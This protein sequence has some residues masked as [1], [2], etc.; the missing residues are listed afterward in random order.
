MQTWRAILGVG[1]LSASGM[2]WGANTEEAAADSTSQAE[3]PP[4]AQLAMAEGVEATLFASGSQLFNP[5]SIDVDHRG[6][7]WVCE[8]VNYRKK[9]NPDGD[10]IKILEDTDGD[11]RADSEKTFYQGADIDGGH[12]VCV[13]GNQVIV[14]VSDRI[15][16]LTDSDGDDVADSKKLLFKGKVLNPVHGQHD[17]AIHSVMFGPDGRLYFNFGNFNS[18]LR[19]ENGTVVTDRFGQPVDGSRKPYMDGMVIRCELDGSEV[20]VLGY[21]FR[22]NWEVTV[23]SFGSMWQSDND[24]G[25]SSCRVNFVMEYGNYGY[26]D[27]VTGLG[28]QSPRT[29]MSPKI[30]ESMW[31]QN[32]PGVVPNLLITGA[33]APTGIL[34]YEGDLLPEP[35]RGQMIHAEPGRNVVWAFP[36]EKSGAGYT[37]T[38]TN[39]AHSEEDRNY[40]PSDVSVAPDG[41]LIIADWY[42][43]VDCCHR[44]IDDTGRLFRV[45]PPGHAYTAPKFDFETPEGATEALGNPNLSARH[46]AWT[47]LLTM[48]SRGRPA[49]EVM[50]KDRNPRYRARALWLLAEIEGNP[51]AAIDMAAQDDVDDVRALALRIARRH[52]VPIEPVVGALVRDPSALVRRECAISLHRLTSSDATRLWGELAQQHDGKD[53]WYLEALGIG[54]HKNEDA[55]FDA[56]LAAAGDD[57]NTTAGRDIIWRSRAPKAAGYLAK[58]LLSADL[59]ES[60]APRLMRALDFH[61][62][63]AKE[64]ALT[65]ILAAG[66]KDRHWTFLEAFRRFDGVTLAARP[67]LVALV[68]AAILES[69]GTITFVDLVA[70]YDRRDLVEDLLDMVRTDPGNPPAIRALQQLLAFGE[71]Q[72]VTEALAKPDQSTALIDALGLAGGKESFTLLKSVTDDESRSLAVRTLAV[73]AMAKNPTGAGE[74][75]K[76]IQGDAVP[77]ELVAPAVRGLLLS[78][79]PDTRIFAAERQKQLAPVGGERWPLEKLLT[80]KPDPT[81]G[82][83]AFTKA[84]CIACHVVSGEGIQ[85]GPELSEIGSKLDRANMISAI[86]EPNQT[87][88]LGFEGL[89]V[90]LNDG[91]QLIGFVSGESETTLSL[92]TIGGLQKDVDVSLIKTRKPM[93]ASLMPAGLDAA[94]SSQELVDLVGWLGTLRAQAGL[95]EVRKHFKK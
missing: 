90:E 41:S 62:G 68:Q 26:R 38:I 61:N 15:L 66:S 22:N 89:I 3:K 63:E 35:F 65:A 81:R 50:A 58:L 27:E 33:G 2:S 1:I 5:S 23:D 30:S 12:G 70:K 83:V 25:S 56:W 16:L 46:L 20:E 47:A 85:F 75:M 28:Y 48:G 11:G 21:N 88:S 37:A 34:V 43:P 9:L 51:Q 84:G 55:C 7:V 54:E 52:R 8:T 42:D 18:E 71:Q 67:D 80:A 49:L 93:R 6:R 29:N 19:R 60:E 14:S 78:P 94:I 53:R 82:K 44:T 39:L 17:H 57:W 74:L 32:D 92:R 76:L 45:A 95:G 77:Q 24:N 31:H 59:L 10:R 91:M 36:I 69:K 86:L 87:V 13:L 4:A 79:N 40:R 73:T 64:A 72:R